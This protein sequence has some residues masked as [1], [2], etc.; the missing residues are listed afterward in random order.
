MG[1]MGT[2]DM[3]ARFPDI[4]AAAIPICGT[5]N[6]QRLSAAKNVNFRIF[7]GDADNVVPVEG[8][9]EAYKALKPTGASVE[10][11]EFPGCNHGSWNPAFNYPDFME[12][13]FKQKKK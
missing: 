4:F 12:W 6:P 13:L 8:S 3:V 10:Y 9:R 2:F 11:I 1:A 5:V 7:H